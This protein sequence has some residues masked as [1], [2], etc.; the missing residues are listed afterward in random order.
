MGGLTKQEEKQT[1]KNYKL[2]VVVTAVVTWVCGV[3]TSILTKMPE[4]VL[5]SPK[6]QLNTNFEESKLLFKFVDTNSIETFIIVAGVAIV[7]FVW[8]SA[9]KKEKK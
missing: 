3:L 8:L 1:M 5:P 7:A 6:A 4:L 9:I 2:P